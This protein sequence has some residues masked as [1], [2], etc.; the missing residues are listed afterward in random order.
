MQK[1]DGL[2]D[3][4]K[5][6]KL[7]MF[8]GKIRKIRDRSSE[9]VKAVLHDKKKLTIIILLIIIV[10]IIILY[11]ISINFKGSK[12]AKY[13]KYEEKMKIYGFDTMYNNKTARTDELVTKA[14]ALKLAIS[15]TFNT[16]NISDFAIYNNE[17]PDA[18]WIEYAKAS[19]I[20]T[21]DINSTNFNDN[22]K[23]I[24]VIQYF[25]NCK[26]IFLKDKN[27]KDTS[28]NITD[29]NS[30]ST[31]QQVAIKD[32]IANGI[33][34]ESAEKIDGGENIFKGKLNELVVN[35]VQKYN[36]ITMPGDKI[37][38]SNEK[39]PSNAN[40]YPYTLA[41]ID[42][43]IYEKPFYTEYEIDKMSPS[44]LYRYKK[45]NYSEIRSYVEGYFASILNI[46]YNTITEENF[47]NSINQYLIYDPND[48]AVKSY[49]DN[50]KTN[51]IIMNGS[52][53]VQFPI[54]YSDG[55]SYRVR[56]RINLNV[57]STN[58]K[59]NL[60]Y[61]DYLN[62]LNKTYQKSSYDIL[63]DYYMTNAMNSKTMFLKEVDLYNAIIGKE[64]S[65][66][67]QEIDKENYSK[68]GPDA[69]E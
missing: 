43:S 32:M 15:A 16:S 31:S 57:L 20:T 36:T 60:I 18:T 30:Y 47:K 38:V 13:I 22:A 41:N 68:E 23:Y 26:T 2:K 14:E 8:K 67:I 48:Y 50:V 46:D 21:E 45:E 54:I 65:G 25:E 5:Q 58:T 40:E 56:V 24:D 7:S 12:Y 62:G 64:N 39:V 63:V 28:V 69:K 52:A 61:L 4:K 55:V 66:I 3:N 59:E 1:N 9:K 10:V 27:T 42:K 44:Q 29:I 19:K 11:L 6:E 34:I 51:K 35:Y 33:I 53:K 17:Y 49:I 37:N